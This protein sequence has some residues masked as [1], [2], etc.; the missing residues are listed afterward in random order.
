MA[1]LLGHEVINL[2]VA[3]PL[4]APHRPLW[5]AADLLDRDALIEAFDAFQP[6]T[7]VHLA[8]ATDCNPKL[9]LSFYS[10]NTEGTSNLLNAVQRTRSIERLIVTSTQ[11]VC[12][13]KH[14]PSSDVDYGPHTTY[15]ASKV[16]TEQATREADLHCAWSIIRPT[17]IWG[18]WLLRHLPFYRLMRRGLYLH[19]A[20]ECIRTWGFVGNVVDQIFRLL[21][22]P[23]DLA[24][25]KTVYVGD[26]PRPL[27]EISNAFSQGFRGKDVRVAPSWLLR[28]TA[29]GGDLLRA[30][31]VPFPLT[32]ERFHSM[33]DDYIVDMDPTYELLGP[34]AF[35]IE[36]GVQAVADWLDCWKS[37]SDDW[38]PIMPR[39]GAA[40]SHSQY[41]VL[42]H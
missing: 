29:R 24:H 11:F 22:L 7:V 21:D 10:A 8:A 20:G 15:G 1:R 12:G 18:P 19:P 9:D 5:S 42:A 35:S 17:N 30:V 27:R 37:K 31:G 26:P 6:E 36:D 33:I 38:R 34:P 14:R 16:I 3:P 25:G 32:T 40:A 39:Q 23:A 2:D 13:P 41:G 4:F 28:G